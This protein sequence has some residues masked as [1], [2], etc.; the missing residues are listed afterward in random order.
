MLKLLWLVLACA[1]LVSLL[2]AAS[3]FLGFE[4]SSTGIKSED[5]ALF[6]GSTRLSGL[7]GASFFKGTLF[8]SGAG[9]L[10]RFCCRRL[11]LLL[12]ELFLLAVPLLSLAVPLLSLLGGAAFSDS[13]LRSKICFWFCGALANVSLLTWLVFSCWFPVAE[14]AAALAATL[15]GLTNA[16]SLSSESDVVSESESVAVVDAGLSRLTN[17]SSP[18]VCHFRMWI[19]SVGFMR[20]REWEREKDEKGER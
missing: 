6:S 8:C 3:V 17:D 15:E 16:T 20:E 5:M 9:F 1:S 18:G 4:P 19:V 2:L 10:P 7:S 13:W 12:L 14:T 11:L